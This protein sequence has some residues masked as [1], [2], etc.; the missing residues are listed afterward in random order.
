MGTDAHAVPEGDG[1]AHHGEGV[2]RAVG[3]GAYVAGD[4]RVGRDV[5]AVAQ[6]QVV[7]V[8]GGRLRDEAALAQPYRPRPREEPLPAPLLCHA[9]R[10]RRLLGVEPRAVVEEAV[11]ALRL[12]HVILHWGR[13]G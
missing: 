8:H 3:A 12:V 9:L 11:V 10:L 1:A 4:I 13:A 2:D 6:V 7:R 5:R